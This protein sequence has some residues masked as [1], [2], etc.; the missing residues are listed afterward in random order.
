MSFRRSYLAGCNFHIYSDLHGLRRSKDV[1]HGKMNL[2][3]E[4]RK[5]SSATNIGVYSLMLS[6]GLG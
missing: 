4:N 2:I 1:E 5:L 6:S 3:M